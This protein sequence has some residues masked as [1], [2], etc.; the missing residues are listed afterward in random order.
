M[1]LRGFLAPTSVPL[2]QDFL[3]STP[4]R[5]R[6]AALCCG[7]GAEV[8]LLLAAGAR[9]VD[10]VDTLP[11]VLEVLEGQLDAHQ[12]ERVAVHCEDALAFLAAATAPYDLVTALGGAPC[13]VGQEA[14]FTAV[15]AR[16]APGGTV[17]V[18]DLV[19]RREEARAELSAFLTVPPERLLTR[20]QYGALL[21][22]VGFAVRGEAALT[23]TEWDDYYERMA[24]YRGL[25][26]GPLSEPA[27]FDYLDDER[28]LLTAPDAPAGYVM[29]RLAATSDPAS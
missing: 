14:L 10:A 25:E 27:F 22:E 7:W 29:L 2:L 21:A 9:T 19:L 5:E 1:D 23:R 28:A 24:S 6:A 18:S 26:V 12:Q 13:Y 4:R 17:V 16:L 20:R 11:A 3:A 15:R 8:H